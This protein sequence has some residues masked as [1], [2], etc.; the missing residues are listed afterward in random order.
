VSLSGLEITVGSKEFTEQLILGQIA[1]QALEAA[2]A[3]VTDRTGLAGTD[4]TRE[5]L[6]SGE[7]DAYWEYTGTG[8]VV[9]LGHEEPIPD[10]Q[11]QY[12]AVAQEDLAKNRIRWLKPAPRSGEGGHAGGRQPGLAD[13]VLPL[14]A[15]SVGYVRYHRRCGRVLQLPQGH[16]EPADQHGL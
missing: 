10:S 1:I 5:A 16:G 15:A 12:E 2:G 9:H 3:T 11:K 4:A 8:R 6:E 13:R 7:I 14:D